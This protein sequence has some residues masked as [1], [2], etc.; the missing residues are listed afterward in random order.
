M[1]NIP[2]PPHGETPLTQG[3]AWGGRGG[4]AQAAAVYAF[5]DFSKM[6]GRNPTQ[7]EL[8]LLSSAYVGSDPN[9]ANTAGGKSAI[10]QYYQTQVN[11]PQAAEEDADAKLKEKV[12]QQYDA[13]KQQFQSVLG[14]DPSQSELDHFST[15]IAQGTADPYSVGQG[16]QTL[17]EY[18]SKQDTTAR[19]A[20]RTELSSADTKYLNEQVM[21]SIT[22]QFAQ[23]GRDVSSGSAPLAAALA[24]AAKQTNNQRETYLATVGHDDY[25]NQR[26]Q[27]INNYL[28]NQARAYQT[29]DQSTMRGYQI[30]DQNTARANNLQDYLTQQSA[31]NDYLQNYGRKNK[32]GGSVFAGAAQGGLSGAAAGGSVGGPWGALIG[33]VAGAGLGAYG[34]SQQR[35]I[36]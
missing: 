33:G 14:R 5:A 19:D 29:A 28:N 8:D 27:T 17:P 32:G 21:P 11:T 2:P 16:L 3:P 20:L 35:S 1:A 12:P 30:T 7:S 23:A 4:G 25:T 34:A 9:I 36:Y 24:N 10:A 13:V 26:Q 22:S 15:M 18:T 6:F 31:Y